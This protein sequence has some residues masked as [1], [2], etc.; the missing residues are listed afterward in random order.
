MDII[1]QL[2]VKIFQALF[3]EDSARRQ[4]PQQ[5]AV[6]L[7]EWLAR[8]QGQAQ[9]AGTPL[10]KPPPL[11]VSP[12]ALQVVPPPIEPVRSKP[13]KVISMRTAP[14]VPLEVGMQH[15]I[16]SDALKLRREQTGQSFRL[17]GRT[18]LEKM[19]FAQVILGPCVAV[20]SMHRGG[21]RPPVWESR[22]KV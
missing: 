20:R 17:P 6:T 15:T 7:E 3:E 18:D 10:Q 1:I 19:I 13:A 8:V 16:H 21:M 11:E 9:P 12:P 14:D 2:I 4:K 5:K 22:G